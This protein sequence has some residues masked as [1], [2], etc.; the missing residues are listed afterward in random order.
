[1]SI[2]TPPE[3][4]TAQSLPTE[5]QISQRDNG[6]LMTPEEFDAHEE[7]DE[8]FNYELVNGVLIVSPAPGPS[9]LDPNGELEHLLRSYA[10]L[11]PGVIDKTL[12]EVTIRLPNGRRRVDRAIWIGLGRRPNIKQDVPTIAV[13]FVSRDRRDRVRDYVTKRAE[14]LDLGI[15]EYWIIDRFQCTL[16][17]FQRIDGADTHQVI[18]ANGIYR[19]PLL[20]GF[21]LSLQTL[22]K[23]ANEWDE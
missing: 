6:R 9:E 1:M 21:E 23:L 4:Q 15:R 2:V 13:E 17:V 7:W 14:Y 12:Y 3:P 10:E 22:L 18:P 19:T 5:Y 20:P 8:E 11:Y 16:T